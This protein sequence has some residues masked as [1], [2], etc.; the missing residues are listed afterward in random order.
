MCASEKT[1]SKSSELIQRLSLLIL[2]TK[3]TGLSGAEVKNKETK[4]KNQRLLR[5]SEPGNRVALTWEAQSR[6]EKGSRHE[7]FTF[8]GF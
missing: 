3:E 2:H 7:T 4:Q 1:V 5:Q 6:T 8:P